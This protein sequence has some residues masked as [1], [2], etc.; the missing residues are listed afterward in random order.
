VKV[1]WF[2]VF[3]IQQLVYGFLFNQKMCRII[4]KKFN[5]MVNEGDLFDPVF[6]D[7]HLLVIRKRLRV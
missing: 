7:E 1:K 6:A 4:K 3:K 2:A 5:N